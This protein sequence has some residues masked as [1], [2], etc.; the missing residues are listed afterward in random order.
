[1][2]QSLLI[3]SIAL[4]FA[5]CTSDTL[6]KKVNVETAKTDW[7]IIRKE[8][9]EYDSA[10]FDDA[11][12][13][14]AGLAIGKALI[15]NKEPLKVDKTYRALLDSA[16]ANRQRK[17]AALAEYE[18]ELA[19]F[20]KLVQ[21]SVKDKQYK[22]GDFD[23]VGN[24]GL[25]YTITNTSGK[26]I[27]GISGAIYAFDIF[28]KEA[29]IFSVNEVQGLKNG[30]SIDRSVF[31][32]LGLHADEAALRDTETSKL[33]FKWVPEDIVYADGESL[34]APAKPE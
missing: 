25:K 22:K 18:N 26:D 29:A 23:F 24:V 2:K 16:K 28:G 30:E 7:E 13:E 32:Q 10:D 5:A 1:M 3:L 8:H 17:E 14:L 20:S 33:K 21:L 4:F 9:T 6:D 27:S 11:L 15:G 19:A 31:Y 12:N 34:K